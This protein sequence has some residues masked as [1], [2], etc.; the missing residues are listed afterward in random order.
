MTD[1]KKSPQAS[2][3][4]AMG[5]AFFDEAGEQLAKSADK[6]RHCV[7]QLSEQQVWWRPTEPQ[8]SVANLILHLCG[9]VRQWIVSGVGGASDVRNRPQEFAERG[10]IP[11]QELLARL[12]DVLEQ[13][14]AVLRAAAT[15]TLLERRRIQGF[16]STGLA[17]IFHCVSHFQGHTQEIICLTRMRLGDAYQFD[18]VPT[19]PEQ[20][21]AVSPA[22]S[23]AL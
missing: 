18:W 15:P 20:Q 4:E 6:I 2:N 9:N 23:T 3:A 13:A 8:N 22:P 10:P 14:E 16:E 17:A 5:R 12:D 11:K 19:T 21:S 1:T 7:R